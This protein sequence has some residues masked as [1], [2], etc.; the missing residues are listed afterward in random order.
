[1]RILVAED[2][3]IIRLDL[4]SLLESA[5]HEVVLPVGGEHDDRNR[6]FVEDPPSGLDPVQLGHLHVEDG[7]V[8]PLRPGKRHRFLPIAGLGADLEAGP[9]EQ[10]PKVEPDDRLVLGDQDPH[11]HWGS[12]TENARL[13]DS[14]SRSGGR[15]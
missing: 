13:R 6:P 9:L 11:P 8:R 7:H 1:M 2:E 15:S 3:T 4:R 5:G 12:L 14:A 10:R